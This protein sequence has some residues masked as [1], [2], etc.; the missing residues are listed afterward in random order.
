MSLHATCTSSSTFTANRHIIW[1]LQIFQVV[2]GADGNINVEPHRIL[3][4]KTKLPKASPAPVAEPTR[5]KVSPAP[6]SEPTDLLSG[7]PSD[8][9]STCENALGEN[10]EDWV[11]SETLELTSLRG[12]TCSELENLAKPPFHAMLC[13]MLTQDNIMGKCAVEACCFC[14]GGQHVDL[15]CEDIPEWAYNAN[16]DEFGCDSISSSGD[17]EAFCDITK[18]YQSAYGL[19]SKTACCVCGGGLKPVG[20][21]S[22]DSSDDKEITGVRRLRLLEAEDVPVPMY[23]MLG[24]DTGTHYVDWISREGLGES[25]GV[26]AL[27]YLVSL[28][29]SVDVSGMFT[30]FAD[31][32]FCGCL[33]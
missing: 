26:P 9:P 8:P 11:V 31:T 2:D 1:F 22:K 10:G 21:Y 16:G 3:A 14:G 29:C 19:T 15:P 6:S 25:T 5:P 13:Q 27:D 23:V 32:H 7:A 28:C 24:G 17:P 4:K 33:E 12:K 30:K 18:D 20:H